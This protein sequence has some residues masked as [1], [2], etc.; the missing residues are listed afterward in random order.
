MVRH[1]ICFTLFS[2]RSIHFLKLKPHKDS[3]WRY[4][5][6]IPYFIRCKKLSNLPPLKRE[7][8][9]QFLSMTRFT[10]DNFFR[11]NPASFSPS[12]FARPE[13]LTPFMKK[14]AL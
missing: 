10:I 5:K 13:V 2:K 7:R 4:V 11:L 8:C 9:L 6:R 3:R 1:Q 12:C 14:K